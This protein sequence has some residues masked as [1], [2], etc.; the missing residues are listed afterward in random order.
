M[1]SADANTYVYAHIHKPYIRCIKGKVIMNI[2]SVGLP[3]DGIA[4]AAYGTVDIIEDGFTTSIERVNFDIEKVVEKYMETG[5]P[6]AGMMIQIVRN[7][8]V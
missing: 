5:Y 1:S 7:A 3:F 2:G 8:S 4:K 6:N